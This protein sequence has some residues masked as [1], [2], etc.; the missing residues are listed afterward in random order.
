MCKDKFTTLFSMS[1]ICR[2]IPADALLCSVAKLIKFFLFQIIFN[3]L[4]LNRR[5]LYFN[6]LI[7]RVVC[8]IFRL[9]FFKTAI[10]GRVVLSARFL[11]YLR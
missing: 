5:F 10:Y 1:V 7:R 3:I 2:K 4:F 6:G 8:V 11:K 9:T